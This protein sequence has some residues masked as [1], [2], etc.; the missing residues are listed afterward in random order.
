MSTPLRWLPT[1]GI[2]CDQPTVSVTVSCRFI[3]L[4]L[5]LMIISLCDV[6]CT[7]LP[8]PIAGSGRFVTPDTC[9]H[10]RLE[11]HKASQ[12]SQSLT[13]PSLET[14]GPAGHDVSAIF[15]HEQAGR[16]KP[17][18][19]GARTPWIRA[20]TALLR[21]E[22]G[23]HGARTHWI[24]GFTA[25]ERPGSGASRRSCCPGR[26]RTVILTVTVCP[27]SGLSGTNRPAAVQLTGRAALGTYDQSRQRARSAAAPR[28][29]PREHS[30]SPRSTRRG[31]G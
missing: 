20:F 10:H 2:T 7:S 28:P 4:Q 11:C 19:H 13:F 17:G 16:L 12:Y 15:V 25:L 5:D 18:L 14:V 3:K 31:R 29:W 26:T 30:A 1:P 22:T 8:E 6:Y 23:P 21:P 9:L 27:E 24:R